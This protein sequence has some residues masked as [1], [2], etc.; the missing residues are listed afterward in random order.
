[1]KNKWDKQWANFAQRYQNKCQRLSIWCPNLRWKKT[2]RIFKFLNRNMN[3]VHNKKMITFSKTSL[4]TQSML[5]NINK[6]KHY[7]NQFRLIELLQRL[8]NINL[9][10]IKQTKTK[11]WW[12]HMD[13]L[14][15]T[16]YLSMM[17]FRNFYKTQV[18]SK[19][20]I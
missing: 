3:N 18:K 1:M 5:R 17:A 19:W 10:I 4:M 20:W 15:L 7:C 8:I 14:L 16:H 6:C 13:L 2:K 12:V 9:T 11:N